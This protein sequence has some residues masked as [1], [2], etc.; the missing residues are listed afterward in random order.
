MSNARIAAVCT[1]LFVVSFL[2]GIAAALAL[3]AVKLEYELC[4][5]VTACRL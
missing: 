2:A 1:G 4:G 5:V 3:S